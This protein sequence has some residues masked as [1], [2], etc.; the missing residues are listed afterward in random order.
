M[1]MPGSLPFGRF[2]LPESCVDIL[3]GIDPEIVAKLGRWPGV[4]ENTSVKDHDRGVQGKI[5]H[6]VGDGDH[7]T[8]PL[9]GDPGE[10]GNDLSLRTGIESTGDFVAE[11]NGGTADEFHR[12]GKST[13]LPPRKHCH[14][15]VG[16]IGDAGPL[17]QGVDKLIPFRGT[18][19]TDPQSCGIGD[20]LRRSEF[21]LGDPELGD[22]SEFRGM[23]VLL[24][25][26]P[27]VPANGTRFFSRRDAR[28]QLE[29][30]ALAASR[31]SDNSDKFTPSEGTGEMGEKSGGI[32]I[33]P[34][35]QGNT[36]KGK[37]GMA[38]MPEEPLFRNP[39]IAGPNPCPESVRD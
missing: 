39:P 21:L 19:P 1:F 26:I 4:G 32:D 17:Q 30:G 5:P 34:E 6:T 38:T 9:R 37:H 27:A 24:G 14:P 10:E 25:E 29:K 3:G 2:P 13:P 11:E 36:F 31:W 22:I 28:D 18:E 20:A 7:E 35:T 15:A 16:E 33:I 23:K 8:V 12:K